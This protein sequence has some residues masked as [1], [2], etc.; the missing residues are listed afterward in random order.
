MTLPLQHTPPHHAHHPDAQL[1]GTALW[2]RWL[3]AGITAGL[4]AY[5]SLDLLLGGGFRKYINIEL[6]WL[7]VLAA[8]SLILLAIAA[9][10]EGSR[11][12]RGEES[13]H[14]HGSL[15]SLVILALPLLLAALSPEVPLGA[16]AARGRLSTSVQPGSFST[17]QRDPRDYHILDWL[18]AF[19]RE[20]D[21]ERFE[22]QEA[23]LLGFVYREVDY[24][25]DL[26]L[27]A[28]I[29]LSCCVADASAVGLPIHHPQAA[30][31][32]AD[33]WLQLRGRFQLGAF[34][35]ERMPILQV[36]E[37]TW[38]EPPEQPYLYP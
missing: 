24:P 5:F 22:G 38:V 3:Q 14:S 33:Q 27:L 29:T 11:L 28:R 2:R 13:G 10:G 7:I 32:P 26:F 1:D 31:L 30:E 12:L 18:R 15:V 23:N 9:V 20:A 19:A 4:A 21:L 34:G 36:E 8:G 16:D 35:D 25:D 6:E 17:L 37:M